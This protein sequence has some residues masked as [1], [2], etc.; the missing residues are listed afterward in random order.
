LLTLCLRYL[1]LQVLPHK[2]RESTCKLVIG[3][4]LAHPL[5]M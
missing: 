4:V 2:V 5:F 1:V 3:M